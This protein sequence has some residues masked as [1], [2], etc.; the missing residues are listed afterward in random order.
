[1]KVY[2]FIKL[3]LKWYKKETALAYVSLL[4]LGLITPFADHNSPS[5][6]MVVAM[7][8]ISVG[9]FAF[10]TG[11]MSGATGSEGFSF[12]Y[13]NSL[14]LT[15]NEIQFL[16]S[17]HAIFRALPGIILV[18]AILQ[19]LRI[20]ILLL[21]GAVFVGLTQLASALH[22][23]RSELF[24]KKHN[25]QF[26]ALLGNKTL[27]TLAFIALIALLDQ[28]LGILTH[29]ERLRLFYLPAKFVGKSMEFLFET[30]AAVPAVIL[31][32]AIL[33]RGNLI[34]WKDEFRSYP[35]KLPT[36]IN[37]FGYASILLIFAMGFYLNSTPP[38][39]FID[40]PLHS[41]IAS[42]QLKKVKT[43]LES[44][45]DI[46]QENRYGFTPIMVAAISG[47]QQI[48]SEL[49]LK[50]A[51]LKGRP[52]E[53]SGLKNKDILYL[54]IKGGNERIIEQILRHK[55]FSLTES[56]A[57]SPVLHLAARECLP[58]SVEEILKKGISANVSTKDGET[59]LHFA[60]KDKCFA[61]IDLLMSHGA[62]PYLVNSEGKSS[63]DMT[64]DKG[65]LFYLKKRAPE[66]KYKI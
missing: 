28:R 40:E 12:R 2:R 14:P 18:F 27:I 7:V 9:V 19:D 23:K 48:F 60:V 35:K 51:H 29:W 10:R 15:R 41:A 4:A 22:Q 49:L 56:V 61:V 63:L 54:A 65:M 52:N 62:D 13:I 46:N 58:K 64:R 37:K 42:G 20:A 50:G 66:V 34:N 25:I 8:V 36:P 21:L 5:F 59:P 11:L 55:S 39:E 32:N 38:F 24:K 45:E 31:T 47:D 3:Y 16:I 44:G 26:N 33:W 6:L 53:R 1:M 57:R 43:L 17:F 30:W